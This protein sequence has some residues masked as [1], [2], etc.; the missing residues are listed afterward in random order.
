[1]WQGGPPSFFFFLGATREAGGQIQRL[2][3]RSCACAGFQGA[4]LDTF[5]SAPRSRCILPSLHLLAA[6][7]CPRTQTFSTCCMRTTC[8]VYSRLNREQHTM[9]GHSCE[10]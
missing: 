4:E 10:R 8:S 5:A 3:A 9:Q 6:M 7:A 2:L 1:M